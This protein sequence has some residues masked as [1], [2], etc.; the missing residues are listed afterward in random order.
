MLDNYRLPARCAV[1]ATS[2]SSLDEIASDD[3]LLYILRLNIHMDGIVY[4][5]GLDLH[6]DAFYLWQ[7]E[8][9]DD[10]ATTSPP[11]EKAVRRQFAE[12]RNLGYREVIV[13]TLSGKISGAADI[14]R[15][16]AV[17]MAREIT[18]YVVDTGTAC[19]PEGHFALEALKLLHLGFAPADVVA[20]LERLKPTAEIIFSVHNTRQLRRKG[21]LNPTEKFF[22]GLLDL[23]PVLRFRDGEFSRLDIGRN[24][25]NTL[26]ALVDAVKKQTHGKHVRAYGLYGG[27][28]DLYEQLAQKLK[29]KTGLEITGFPISPVIGA[30]LGP[31]AVGVGWV[32]ELM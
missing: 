22:T 24:T 10:A 20:H 25:E 32:E 12:L 8:T 23:K 27:N 5:D 6:P 17:E 1:V 11:A 4:S 19:M 15:K 21:H 2:T 16:V 26:D 13:T 29:D 7:M 31:D 30:H 3:D 14:I 18:V 9:P 28:R